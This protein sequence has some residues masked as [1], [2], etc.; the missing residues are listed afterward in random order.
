MRQSVKYLLKICYTNE[1]L[2][3]FLIKGQYFHAACAISQLG[4]TMQQG[5]VQLSKWIYRI[6]IK[7]RQVSCR[8]L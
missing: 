1:M 2:N 5:S 3:D 7:N 4:W 8:V 6:F